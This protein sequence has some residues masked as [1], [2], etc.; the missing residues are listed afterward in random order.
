[1]RSYSSRLLVASVLLMVLAMV[2]ALAQDRPLPPSEAAARMTLPEG[3]QATLF[4]GEPDVVQPIGFTFDDRGRLWVAECYSY[5]KWIKDGKEG[6]DRVLIF[7]DTDGDGRFDRRTIFHDKLANVSGI[8]VGFGGVWLCATPHLLFIPDRNADDK[9]DGPPEVL[10]DGWSLN[11]KHN[12]FNG[13]QWGPDGWLYGCNGI[14]DTSRVGKPGTPDAQRVPMNCGVWRYHP[15]RK[16]FEP[17]AWGTTNPW[18]LDWNDVGEMFITN[19]VIHHLWHVVQG[20]H[21][22]RMYGQDLNPQVYGLMKSC[23]DHIHWGGGTWQSSRGGQGTHS[24]AGGGHAHVGCMIYLGDNWPERYRNGVFMLNLHGSRV[25]HDLLERRGAGYVARHCRDFLFA[26]DPWFRGLGIQYGPDGGVFISDWCD[27]GE[28]HNYDKVHLSGR[29]YK[30]THGKAKPFREDL[31]KLGDA[32][33]LKRLEHRNDWH[34]RHASRLL[35]ERAAAGKLEAGTRAE[36]RRLTL[37]SRAASLQLRALWTAHVT[38]S[39]DEKLLLEVLNAPGEYLRGW[40]VRLVLEKGAP[41]NGILAKLLRMAEQ[42][43]SPLVRLH[44]ASGLQRLPALPRWQL[45]QALAKR[46]EDAEDAYL[47]LMLWYGVEPLVGDP[48][49]RQEARHLLQMAD[50][51]L[52]RQYIARRLVSLPAPAADQPPGDLPWLVKWVN[53]PSAAT[54]RDVLRGIQEA[55]AGQRRVPMPAEWPAAFAVLTESPLQEVRDRALALAVVFGDEKAVVALRKIVSD[56]KG[57]AAARQSALQTLVFMQKP[58]L[59]PLLHEL[60]SD[61]VLRAPALRGLAAFR[62]ENTPKLILKHYPSFTEDEKSDA[63]QTL[64]SR[65][66]YALALLDAIERGQ[67]ERRDVSAY[68]VRQMLGLKD[69]QVALQLEKIWGTIRPASQEKTALMDRYRK[70]LTPGF[71]KNADRSHGRL[72]YARNCAACHRLFDD[73]KDVGPDLTGSQRANLDYML[74]NLL[75]PS[76]LV[77]REYQV[78]VVATKNGR[79]LTGIIK[80]ETERA[81]TVATQNETV[82][83]PKEDIEAREQSPVSMMPEGMLDKLTKEEVRDLIAYLAGA[84]QAPLPREGPKPK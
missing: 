29:I 40:G 35:Q 83:I 79:T 11:A 46:T 70:M 58:E 9:P 81:L 50:I 2:T 62:D 41:S 7:E 54:Q 8:Q 71:L 72:V 63:V 19:C 28:C 34:A 76:A 1:M 10:L 15:L 80:Q 68:T 39:A 23:A 38:G 16:Q 65:P 48:T 52:L 66:A 84:G 21:Y 56:P 82:L 37:L 24:E 55:L 6:T 18:G 74:E 26:N 4:A 61:P 20:A 22:E 27:T 47:P 14:T 13:L 75:D 17:Y 73:G 64:A 43:P 77:G 60:L 45:A 53:A 69:K 57:Q 33:L 51:P 30:V 32:E 67:V 78:T 3:F 42:D 59:T 44:L 12:V 25:N 36:L 31:A 5:P 49:Y